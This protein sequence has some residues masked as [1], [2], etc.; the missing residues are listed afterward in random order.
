[1]LGGVPEARSGGRCLALARS[2][3]ICSTVA[4]LSGDAATL[5]CMHQVSIH[6]LFNVGR[7]DVLLQIDGKF[8]LTVIRR[9][10]S[11]A[12]DHIVRVRPTLK[13]FYR[14]L[15]EKGVVFV[16]S[17]HTGKVIDIKEVHPGG[18]QGIDRVVV[19]QD[20]LLLFVP[21]CLRG[22]QADVVY[23]VGARF[24]SDHFQVFVPA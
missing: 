24:E 14:L 2:E 23:P 6:L 8:A 17:V 16:D 20:G 5:Y 18:C 11:P 7:V 4:H 12:V 3:R 9:I 1:M 13:L 10:L 19:V 15:V 21:V 22:H